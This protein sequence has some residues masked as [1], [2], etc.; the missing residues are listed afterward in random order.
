MKLSV[1]GR[2]DIERIL[3]ITPYMYLHA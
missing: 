1:G 3:S 2:N